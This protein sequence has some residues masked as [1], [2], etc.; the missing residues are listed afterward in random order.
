MIRASD[1]Y[2]QRGLFQEAYSRFRSMTR[3][4]NLT[5]N[6]EL[7]SIGLQLKELAATYAAQVDASV[8]GFTVTRSSG[9]III[10]TAGTPLVNPDLDNHNTRY[11][12][13]KAIQ[14]RDHGAPIVF[15]KY[16]IPRLQTTLHFF[17]KAIQAGVDG[18]WF[19]FRINF[20]ESSN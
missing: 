19:V 10:G 6:A 14:C 7:E 9:I 5:S 2:R 12:Y 1:Y 11:E 3:N 16:F 8:Q 17:A 15:E 20:F 4:A 13:A 18:T